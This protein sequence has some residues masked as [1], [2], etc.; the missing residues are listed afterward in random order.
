MA[1]FLRLLK[2][3]MPTTLHQPDPRFAEVPYEQTL[4]FGNMAGSVFYK[5]PQWKRARYVALTT[6]GNRCQLC[7]AG[8]ATGPLHVDHIKPRSLFPERCLDPTNL[9]VLCEDCHTAKGVLYLDDMRKSHTKLPAR[10][11]ADFFRIERKHLVLADRAPK[12]GE[13]RL[14]GSGARAATKN[15]RKRWRLLVKFCSMANISYPQAARLTVEEFMLTPWINNHSF[16]RFLQ[17]G[18]DGAKQPDDLF[19]DV[20]G[21]PF[22]VNLHSLLADDQRIIQKKAA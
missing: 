5:T 1:V 18:G 17:N 21:C 7:G 3:K 2:I 22:P 4:V 8:P 13:A 16:Q 12:S 6:Y 20:D 14:L 10:Q 11:L 15:Q 19:F 9:Q